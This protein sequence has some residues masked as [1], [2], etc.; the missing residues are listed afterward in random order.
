V[1]EA[2][3]QAH[4]IRRQLE[5]PVAARFPE[6]SEDLSAQLMGMLGPGFLRRTPYHWLT[7]LPRYLKAA[8]YRLEKLPE[9]VLRDGESMAQ[10]RRLAERLDGLT[11]PLRFSPESEP[12]VLQYRWMLE[13]L[14][15]SL[16]AQQ[17]GTS[18]PVSGKRMDKQWEKVR[19]SGGDSA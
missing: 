17:L 9:T 18:L 3:E 12:D 2:L 5:S 1:G 4:E 14:R 8:R 6:A 7:Q 16:F 15:V 13:E 19:M 10:V 11:G